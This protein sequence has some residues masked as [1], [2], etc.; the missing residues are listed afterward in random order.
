MRSTILA[1]ALAGAIVW[2]GASIA[3]HHSYAA[4]YRQDAQITIEGE[5][6]ALVYRNPHS[7]IQVKAPDADKRMRV[8]A[9]E[10]GSRDE[11]REQILSGDAL[12]PGDRV[13]VTGD[14]ARDESYARL[15]MR[16]IVRPR[17]GRRWSGYTR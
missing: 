13:I 10:C 14:A 8:W 2:G 3:A 5:L 12:K 6:V 17:D 11:L 9:V 15:R 16:T 7:Y 4:V 1:V